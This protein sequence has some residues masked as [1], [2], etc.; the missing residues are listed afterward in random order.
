[1]RRLTLLLLLSVSLGASVVAIPLGGAGA[2][3]SSPTF[4]GYVATF[5]AKPTNATATFNV[6]TSKCL[7]TTGLDGYDTMDV[8]LVSSAG[9][10]GVDLSI[11][12]PSGVMAYAVSIYAGGG[13]SS[14]LTVAPGDVLT[15][16]ARVGATG[17]SYTVSGPGV[18]TLSYGGPLFSATSVDVGMTAQSGPFPKFHPEEFTH[19]K[20]NGETLGSTSPVGYDEYQASTLEVQAS[21]LNPS[22]K[23]FDLTYVS[24][25]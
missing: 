15:F 9:T 5:A 12:C 7:N 6:P 20:I 2:L 14:S 11:T 8:D 10:A 16:K 19:V 4:A 25:G 24:Q 18:S 3:T 13:V 23:G 17:M 1:M 22:G 21:A